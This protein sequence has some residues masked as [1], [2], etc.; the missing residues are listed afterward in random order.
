MFD[1]ECAVEKLLR[2]CYTEEG[3]HY[4]L[5]SSKTMRDKPVSGTALH[6][7]TTFISPLRM[8]PVPYRCKSVRG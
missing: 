8:A 2:Q 7:R 4:L 3:R 6:L 5:I 1:E